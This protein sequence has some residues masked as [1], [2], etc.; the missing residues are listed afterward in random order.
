MTLC[1]IAA[2]PEAPRPHWA[3]NDRARQLLKIAA[4]AGVCAIPKLLAWLSIPI[5]VRNMGGGSRQFMF[6]SFGAAKVLQN[7]F[8]GE[9]LDH[10]RWAVLTILVGLGIV[11]AV[12]R[13]SPQSTFVLAGCS[14]WL[15]LYF[16]RPTWGDALY[17]VGISPMFQL[18][19]LIGPV[20]IFSVFL[21]ALGISWIWE[22]SHGSGYALLGMA[23]LLAPAIQER[24]TYLQSNATWAAETRAAFKIDGPSIQDALELAKQRGGRAYAGMP[25][26]WGSTFKIGQVP[27]YSLFP[28]RQIPCLGY[29]YISFLPRNSEM[30]GFNDQRT[31]DYAGMDVRT[32]IT[33]ALMAPLPGTALIGRFGRFAVYSPPQPFPT[34]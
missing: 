7:A 9:L 8:T 4:L 6:D 15:I 28:P 16:G 21:G 24:R 12:I 2:I 3:W 18:H 10:G 31:A 25:Y 27:F 29:L 23:L 34:P 17:L 5:D 26:N 1:L 14:A 19:R 32:I 33:P 30:Y 11:V 20:Q 22:R 13:K